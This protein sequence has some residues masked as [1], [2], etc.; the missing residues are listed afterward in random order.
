MA[1]LFKTLEDAKGN[2]VECWGQRKWCAGEVVG[3][4]NPEYGAYTKN[5]EE[6]TDSDRDFPGI[7]YGVRGM[8]FVTATVASSKNGSVWTEV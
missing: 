3:Q 4:W 1:Y 8:E 6:L 5:G 7:E 2:S